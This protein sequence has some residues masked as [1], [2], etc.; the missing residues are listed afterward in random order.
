MAAK[1]YITEFQ[2][3]GTA[4]DP[5][6]SYRHYLHT[7][8]YYTPPG[9]TAQLENANSPIQSSGA[10]AASAAFAATTKFIRIKTDGGGPINYSIG[11]AAV[12]TVSSAHL[13]ANEETFA[14]VKPG[15]VISVIVS[16]A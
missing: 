3:V 6:S 14:A 12:A 2:D 16:A 13:S 15:D 10:A 7:I 9:V 8:P 11:A 4:G 5:S 1:V